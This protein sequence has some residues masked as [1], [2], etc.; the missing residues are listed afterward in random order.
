[1][2][3]QANSLPSRNPAGDQTNPPKYQPKYHIEELDKG[4]FCVVGPDG[5]APLDEDFADPLDVEA[6]ADRLNRRTPPILTHHV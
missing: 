1:M 6:A 4:L 3:L 5:H 2:A